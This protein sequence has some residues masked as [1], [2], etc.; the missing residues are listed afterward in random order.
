MSLFYIL[1][2]CVNSLDIFLVMK[3]QI[4]KLAFQ[5]ILKTI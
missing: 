2:F 1:T 5:K 3:T 4:I